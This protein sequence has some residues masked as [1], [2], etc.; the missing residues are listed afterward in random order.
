MSGKG[1]GQPDRDHLVAALVAEGLDVGAG[2]RGFARR[3]T[4]RCRQA[5]PLTHSRAAAE[6]TLLLHHPVLLQPPAVISRV[7]GALH[8]VVRWYDTRDPCALIV[9]RITVGAVA[10]HGDSRTQSYRAR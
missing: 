6:N 9:P 5:G 4:R 10:S 1:T 7:A 2:F 8:K 3:G